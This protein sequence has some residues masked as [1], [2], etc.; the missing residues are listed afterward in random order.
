MIFSTLMSSAKT[1]YTQNEI[2][3]TT[4]EN[5]WQAF[6]HGWSPT[7][8]SLHGPITAAQ[9]PPYTIP[10]EGEAGRRAIPALYCYAALL[11]TEAYRSSSPVKESKLAQA[12]VLLRHC[13]TLACQTF[14]QSHLQAVAAL[15]KL[16]LV[17]ERQ[18][19]ISEAIETIEQ[20][21][22]DGRTTLGKWHPRQLES[23]RTMGALLVKR[24]AAEDQAQKANGKVKEEEKKNGV[25]GE[26]A[27]V[28]ARSR[29]RREEEE[30]KV[31][32]I[33]WEVLEGRVRMLGKKH[34][35]SLASRED[36][37]EWLSEKG[38]WT[39]EGLD[40]Q[41]LDDIWEWTDLGREDYSGYAGVGGAVGAGMGRRFEEYVQAGY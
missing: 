23:L 36:L 24:W 32:A 12:E 37:I 14:H 22:R 7:S 41:R 18:G 10:A 5:V 38:R 19:R 30:Q 34:E 29:R 25:N 27:D 40:K 4:L 17:L 35:S 21:V 31:E 28:D 2:T 8:T 6:V 9:R 11:A 33:L 26:A 13:H 15:L 20:A 3:S 16:Q 1:I 39:A